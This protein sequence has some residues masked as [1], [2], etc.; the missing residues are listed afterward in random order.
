MW[1]QLGVHNRSW[2]QNL[3]LKS[4]ISELRGQGHRY[5][6]HES[7]DCMLHLI[8]H[9]IVGYD[10]KNLSALCISINVYFKFNMPKVGHRKIKLFLDIHFPFPDFHCQFDKLLDSLVYGGTH[11]HCFTLHWRPSLLD[12]IQS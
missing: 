1:I 10:I 3:G 11:M 6:R 4:M 12:I 2:S 8:F 5:R 7:D 9:G